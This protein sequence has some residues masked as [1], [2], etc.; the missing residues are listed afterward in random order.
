[1]CAPRERSLTPSRRTTAPAGAA[2]P[3]LQVKVKTVANAVNAVLGPSAS[4]AASEPAAGHLESVLRQGSA[5][6][7]AGLCTVMQGHQGLA[8]VQTA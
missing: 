6:A 7:G 2:N 1:M 5:P 3:G 4:S 8:S